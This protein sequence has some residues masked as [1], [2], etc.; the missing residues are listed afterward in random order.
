MVVCFRGCCGCFWWSGCGN[1]V[2]A[3]REEAEAEAE[4]AEV[5]SESESEMSGAVD[6]GA[7]GVETA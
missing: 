2:G 3:L 1:V 4:A 5:E 7:V 6:T